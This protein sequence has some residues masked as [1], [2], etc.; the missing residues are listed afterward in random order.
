[1]AIVTSESAQPSNPAQSQLLFTIHDTQP[2]FCA[3]SVTIPAHLVERLYQLAL[4]AQQSH[5]H[6]PGFAQHNAPMEYIEQTFSHN[7]IEHLK[8]FLFKYAVVN[9]LYEQLRQHKIL[10]AGDPRLSSVFVERGKNAVFHFELCLFPSIPF[11]EWKYFPFK[12][13]KRKNYKDLDRQVEAFITEEQAQKERYS[14]TEIGI[15]DWVHFSIRLLDENNNP[16]FADTASVFWLRI[17]DEE[18]DRYLSDLFVNKSVGQTIRT[19]NRSIQEF[20]SDPFSSSYNYGIE[21][22][23]VI[24]DSYFCLDL[25]KHQF[26]LKTNKEISQKFIEVYSYRN[27]LSLRRSM[28]EEAMRVLLHK[29]PFEVPNYLA[30]RAQHTLLEIVQFNPDYYVYRMQKDFKER[31]K[32]LAYRQIQEQIF[33]DQMAYDENIQL[34]QQDTKAYLNLTL[35]PRTKEFIY[36]DPPITKIRGQEIPI[37][38]HELTRTC[39]REKTLNYIIYHLTKK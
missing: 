36:F 11:Q 15:G 23:D 27:D 1:M 31:I 17:G 25:F 24:P 35:R 33:I 28:S 26:R 21:I 30:L 12:A 7:I 9:F 8:E 14:T 4:W 10:I 18:A 13:P 29:H 6:A 20:F 2:W 19:K 34:S 39:L 37:H 38:A 32:E 3:T 16:V 22:L 5:V